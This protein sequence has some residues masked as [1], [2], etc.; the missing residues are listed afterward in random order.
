MM[1]KIRKTLDKTSADFAEVNMEKNWNNKIVLNNAE[2][3]KVRSGNRTLFGVRVLN[4]NSWGFASSND[5]D[6]LEE[7]VKKAKKLAKVSSKNSINARLA[8]SPINKGKYKIKPEKHPNDIGIDEKLERCLEL[9]KNGQEK[10]IKSTTLQYLDSHAKKVYV[11]TEGTELT[12]K[13]VRSFFV[14]KAFTQGNKLLQASK[15]DAGLKGVEIL[16]GKEKM[17]KETNKKARLLLKSRSPPSGKMTVVINPKMAGTLAHEAIGHA[18]EGDSVINGKSILQGKKEEKIG[19]EKVTIKDDP[20]LENFFGSYPFDSEGVEGQETTLIKE[21]RLKNFMHS[22]ETAE[23]EEVKPTG[24]GR[25]QNPSHFPLVR[26]SNTFFC[27]GDQTEEELFEGIEK[28]V[29][30]HGMKGGVSNTNSGYFQFAAE[31][32]QLIENGEKTKPLRDVTL[33]G[34][35]MK[36][37][38]KVSGA[39]KEKMLGDPGICGKAGQSVPVTDGGPSIRIESILVGGNKNGKNPL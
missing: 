14:Y 24:N 27:E 28:G 23:K 17:V 2:V 36:T 29:Y 9:S 15:R 5:P 26:M 20:T 34:N 31:Y 25:A 8:E 18:C 11:N 30:V 4:N 6:D 39:G 35:I 19:S 12:Y 3:D 38:K 33:V 10:N 1:D 37:L 22:R 13:P 32:G 7:C 21:G 16:D